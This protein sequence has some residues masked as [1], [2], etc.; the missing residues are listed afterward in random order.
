MA[1]TKINT[2]EL[3][4]LGTTNSS[5]RLPSGDT[6]SRPSNPN[7]GEL[8]YNTDDNY[9]EYWDGSAWFQIDYES[10]VVPCT[11][12]TINY[13]T[14]VTAYY[15]M[16]DATDQTGNYNGTPTNVNFNVAGKFGN[17]GSFNGSSSYITT[18]LKSQNVGTFSFWFK[19]STPAGLAT[20]FN[21]NNV[22]SAEKGVMIQGQTNGTFRVYIAQGN[23]A[24][25]LDV[26]TTNTFFDNNWHNAV[27]T[28]DL[29][30]SGTNTYLYVDKVV[31][32]SGT[33]NTGVWTSGQTS[34]YNLLIGAGRTSLQFFNGSIDQ[35][36]IFPTALTAG[37]V[38]S[39]YNELQC[40]PTIVPTNNFNV[41]TY[42]GT[43]ATQTIDAKF[44]EAANFNGSSSYITT[45]HI[46]SVSGANANFSVSLWFKLNSLTAT[47]LIQLSGNT[48]TFTHFTI[49]VGS[50]GLL[51]LD[52]YG[53][54][55]NWSGLSAISANQWYNVI[56]VNTGATS[57]AYL[58]GLAS[59]TLTHNLT[60]AGTYST[61]GGRYVNGS[62]YTGDLTNGSIDQVRIFNTALTGPQVT[63]LYTNET[64]ATAQLLNFPVGAGCIAAY[65]LDGNA[66]DISGLYSGTPTDIGYTGMEF[67]P[68]LVWAKRRSASEDNALFD[69]LR[70]VQK[71]I[72]SNKTNAESTKTNA[73]SSFNSNGFTTGAN[74]ALNTSG[75]TYV[76]WNWKAGGPAVAANSIEATNAT[77]SA[78]VDAGFS[79]MKFHTSAST[80]Q[81]PP[82]NYIEHG[83]D[84][85]PEMV[86]YKK[87]NE[88]QNWVVQ[89]AYIQQGQ[90]LALN[91]TNGVGANNATGF[92]DNTSTSIGVRS[93]FAIS[94]DDP[95][96]AYAF[97]SVDGYSKIGS[98]VG[99]GAAGNTVVTGF[100]PAFVMI[101]QS[102]NIGTDNHWN[103][104]DNKR[105]EYDMLRADTSD[106]EFAG[107][108]TR[109]NFL[110]NG[111]QM[112]DSDTSRNTNGGSYI[113]MAF[114][115]D[116]A[117]EPVLAN[118]FD[119][120]TYTG[121]GGT[122]SITSLDFQPDLVWI[123]G[124][125][126][127]SQDHTIVDSVRGISRRIRPS[128]TSAEALESGFN[129]TAFNSDGFTLVDNT[130]GAYNV[131]GAVG[132]LYSGAA[133]YV[134]WC[135]KASNDST[136]NQDGS[137]TSIVSANPAAGFSI[138]KYTNQSGVNTVGH[139][140][141]SPP[142]VI[143]TK[144][145]G[146]ND[147]WRMYHSSLGPNWL[148]FLNL[149][150]T[151][152]NSPN[153]WNNTAP[154]SSVFTL[155]SDN[156]SISGDSIA[157]C[158]SSVDGYS[159]FGSY[160]GGSTN[161]ISLGFQPR[162]VLVKNRT[163]IADWMLFDSERDSTTTRL[164]LNPNLSA[165]ESNGGISQQITMSADGFNWA[166]ST[167]VRVNSSGSTYIYMAFA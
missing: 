138:V 42:V 46:S 34:S 160:A 140:L 9:V 37:N 156:G 147:N 15:K 18:S 136:I 78:N 90:S 158:F 16:E 97:H 45:P 21:N 108:L 149:N 47:N 95:Y 8:R 148:I 89:S 65:K 133:Q 76:S 35:V 71:Q 121:N 115:A 163:T 49:Q 38:T 11:T 96:I 39:L 116:P 128:Y 73:I 129:V 135:W 12:N 104:W 113:F 53:S 28:W 145:L 56:V 80:V 144:P 150:V 69:S 155:G 125:S 10:T 61:I 166:T 20:L 2:P 137:I 23:G 79:I 22:S 151:G 99:T 110:N 123:K 62:I 44:N 118:S 87:L 27:L 81:P 58:N 5:L 29:N 24:A 74:N 143:I 161:T 131:N 14:A 55:F 111:F 67:A 152:G 31:E 82:M 51:Y 60:Y 13:P 63:D 66:D 92:F 134:A 105:V 126:T 1:I 50:N 167:N 48:S 103:M 33:A 54:A 98:Y 142:N 141:S 159:K 153:Q 40:A 25:A 4:D 162:F 157:Y 109:I 139:G 7:T 100:R 43:G 77:R 101:K 68:D 120:V 124:R 30:S 52:A 26:Y 154:T 75:Q 6:A 91:L 84:A 57:I 3:F 36:R 59:N 32:A 85:T 88:V 41:N 130:A 114:A 107:S 64:D 83:L 127:S 165:A 164:D 86:I 93:N 19:G 112:M 117:P 122:Q 102:S 72:T 119:T 94:R 17:A 70:G 132:G 146:V 106:S